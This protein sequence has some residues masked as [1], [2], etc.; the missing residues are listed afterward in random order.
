M[1]LDC[2]ALHVVSS[3]N[4]DIVVVSFGICRKAM[5]EVTVCAEAKKTQSDPLPAN[6]YSPR[7]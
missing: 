5:G 7:R 1:A 2:R 3:V 6:K 4:P